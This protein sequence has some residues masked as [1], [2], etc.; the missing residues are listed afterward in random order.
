MKKFLQ[1]RFPK[2]VVSNTV[3]EV[4]HA[5]PNPTDVGRKIGT[6]IISAIGDGPGPVIGGIDRPQPPPPPTR[7]R[8]IML[9]STELVRD[10]SRGASVRWG[11]ELELGAAIDLHLSLF[12]AFGDSKNREAVSSA[13][14]GR[15]AFVSV[16]IFKESEQIDYLAVP[17]FETE[18]SSPSLA[19]N[20][21]E[22]F[23]GK[24]T[25]QVQALIEPDTQVSLNF[26]AKESVYP[27]KAVER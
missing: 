7:G 4:T 9:K 10:K 16:A 6:A 11:L 14:G 20:I 27:I 15:P 17:W 24:T 12:L 26:E 5:G 2:P 8:G 22:D 25:I 3:S 21:Q 23:M 19:M 18:L 1:E 13:I